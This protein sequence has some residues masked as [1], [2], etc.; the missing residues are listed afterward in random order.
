MFLNEAIYVHKTASL[1]DW[2]WW[3]FRVD[4]TVVYRFLPK[5]LQGKTVAS[6][7]G[8]FWLVPATRLASEPNST[9][10]GAL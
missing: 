10:L 5:T 3:A 2:R 7:P 8:N 6:L 1:K 9:L 4:S